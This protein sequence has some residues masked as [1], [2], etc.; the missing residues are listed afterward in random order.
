MIPVRQSIG[1]LGNLMFKQ[2]YL[3]AQ[4]MEGL[5]PDVYVQGEQYFARYADRIKSFYSAGIGY[6][7]KVS[8]HIRRGDYLQKDNFYVDL[9]AGDYYQRAVDMF[10]GEQFIVFC[11]DGQD[12]EQDTA[13]RAWCAAFLEPLI[14]KQGKRWVFAPLENSETEDLNLMASC[15]HNIMANSTFSWWAAYLNPTPLKTVI[16]PEKWFTDGLQ[17][18]ELIPSWIKI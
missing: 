7:D 9:S 4:F 15:K 6:K 16:C 17:R 10:P 11:K 18:C 2:A 14:G 5:I 8:L 12:L 3:Y 13:D 1:G